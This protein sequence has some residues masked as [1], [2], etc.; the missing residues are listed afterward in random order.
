MVQQRN[1]NELGFDLPAPSGGAGEL[2]IPGMGGAA[3]E[4][5]IPGIGA[6]APKVDENAKKLKAV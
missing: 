1:P 3:G 5:G 2:G 6:P 4:L